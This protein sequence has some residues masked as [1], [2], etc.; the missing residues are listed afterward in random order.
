[1]SFG[2]ATLVFTMECIFSVTHGSSAKSS[3]VYSGEKTTLISP[4]PHTPSWVHIFP[5]AAV[6]PLFTWGLDLLQILLFL[7][8]STI[9]IIHSSQGAQIALR[10][11][12]RDNW[13]K[14]YW[15]YPPCRTR[16]GKMSRCQ[17]AQSKTKKKQGSLGFFWLLTHQAKRLLLPPAGLCSFLG[18]EVQWPSM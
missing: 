6:H 3:T 4:P 13:L 10:N 12:F 15:H 7:H 2:W 8:L 17:K 5:H 18:R 14:R 16:G 11:L 9:C 1:M